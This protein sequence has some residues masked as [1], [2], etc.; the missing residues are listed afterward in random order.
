MANRFNHFVPGGI[1][2]DGDD[3]H[4]EAIGELIAE[5]M[6]EITATVGEHS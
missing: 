2:S 1:E 6:H 3:Y 4:E 5:C